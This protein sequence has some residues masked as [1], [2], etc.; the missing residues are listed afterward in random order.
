ML[1]SFCCCD[2]EIVRRLIS[3]R[4]STHGEFKTKPRCGD[5]AGVNGVDSL[6]TSQEQIQ[7]R[8]PN[9][10]LPLIFGVFICRRRRVVV[11]R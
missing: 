9:A 4:Y 8:V 5:P 6:L 7:E 1:N 3:P 10:P 2:V 11:N